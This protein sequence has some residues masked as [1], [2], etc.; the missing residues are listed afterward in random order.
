VTN[1]DRSDSV[2]ALGRGSSELTVPR[3]LQIARWLWIAST[4]VGFARSLVQLSDRRLLISELR[5]QAPQVPQEQLDSAVNGGVLF[6]IVVWSA[7]LA[8]YAMLSTRMVQGRNWA[9]ILL[10]VLGGL[11]VAGTAFTLIL[12]GAMGTATMTAMTGVRVDAWETM[13]GV[14]T[15]AMDATA[16]VLMVHPNSNRFFRDVAR[17]PTPERGHSGPA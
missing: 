3:Q 17:L 16:M 5:E 12:V 10:L 13:F 2:D 14:I 8:V 6:M 7:V 9:R 1:P 11:S 4:L 15:V